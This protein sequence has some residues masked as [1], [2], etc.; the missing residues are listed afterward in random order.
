MDKVF[1]PSVKGRYLKLDL[2]STAHY[3][4]G[5]KSY[6]STYSL[7]MLLS[8]CLGQ[9]QIPH[10]QRQIAT[11]L[12]TQHIHP[13]GKEISHRKVGKKLIGELADPLLTLSSFCM[14]FYKLSCFT[15]AIGY[16]RIIRVINPFK[17]RPLWVLGFFFSPFYHV[18]VC[19][20]PIHCLVL[21][22]SIRDG[23]IFR[24]FL[25]CIFIQAFD[26]LQQRACLISSDTK[27]PSPLFTHFHDFFVIACRITSD[28]YLLNTRWYLLVQSS[29]K[30][31]CFCTR[32]SISRTKLS[33][34][35][36]ASISS[37]KSPP[38]KAL[39]ESVRI[40]S[41]SG[42]PLSRSLT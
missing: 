9:Y 27:L 17:K 32:M 34:N 24:V 1:P 38:T 2:T 36:S 25:P 5:N 41:D 20:W 8:I 35:L 31:R 18:P 37:R 29:K 7:D 26:G 40:C 42:Y 14:N 10:P 33:V 28:V 30:C 19:L 4:G 16:H 11:K 13:V 12:C 23:S 22:L 15:F 3:L 6:T 39:A 21:H